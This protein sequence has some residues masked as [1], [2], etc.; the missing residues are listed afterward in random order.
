MHSLFRCACLEKTYNFIF[1]TTYTFSY[2]IRNIIYQSIR[3][4][5]FNGSY[6]LH[7]FSFKLFYIIYAI[8]VFKRVSSVF[9]L[10]F[11]SL[12]FNSLSFNSIKKFYNS[13]RLF[14]ILKIVSFTY[15]L[16][17]LSKYFDFYNLT[18]IIY[19]Y[20]YIYIYIN[21]KKNIKKDS[22]KTHAK[23]IKIFL[24]KKSKS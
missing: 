7:F 12:S 19:I 9:L 16:S 24:R 6:F 5:V 15:C 22:E 11:F 18:F 10:I 2:R 21:D 4:G 23:D 13:K 3:P 14:F 17:V 20:I 8:F 1:E